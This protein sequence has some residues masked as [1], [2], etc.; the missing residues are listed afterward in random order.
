MQAKK[1]LSCGFAFLLVLAFSGVS[2]ALD[3]SDVRGTWIRIEKTIAKGKFGAV[4]SGDWFAIGDTLVVAVHTVT[5]ATGISVQLV[6]P[7]GDDA[8]EAHDV[9]GGSEHTKAATG[10][11]AATASTTDRSTGFTITLPEED[12]DTGAR[13]VRFFFGVVPGNTILEKNGLFAQV[14]VTGGGSRAGGTIDNLMD[15]KQILVGATGFATTPVGDGKTFGIDNR[16]PAHTADLFERFELMKVDPENKNKKVKIEGSVATPVADPIVYSDLNESIK[17]GQDVTVYLKLDRGVLVAGDADEASVIFVKETFLI[18]ADATPTLVTG[19]TAGLR[20]SAI[21]TV[22][23][24]NLYATGTLEETLDTS[25]GKFGDGQRVRV[26][27]YLKDEAGNLGGDAVTDANPS[28]YDGQYTFTT[29]DGGT[30]EDR[31]NLFLIDTTTPR[32]TVAYPKEGAPDST[33]L[34]AKTSQNI[35]YYHEGDGLL[36]DRGHS[37]LLKHLRLTVSEDIDSIKVSH[38]AK[39]FGKGNNDT[40][41]TID[42]SEGKDTDAFDVDL[43]GIAEYSK[44]T[45]QKRVGHATT[46]GDSLTGGI[47]GTLEIIAY[48]RAGN[49]PDSARTLANI[50]F[51]GIEPKIYNQFPTADNAPVDSKGRRTISPETVSPLFSVGE[52]LDSLSVRYVQKGTTGGADNA[53]SNVWEGNKLLY[54]SEGGKPSQLREV[55]VVPDSL[56]D[57]ED[58]YLQIV[59]VDLAGNAYV[60]PP[61]ELRFNDEFANPTADSFVVATAVKDEKA[62]VVGKAL[63]LNLTAL[64]SKMTRVEGEDVRAVVYKGQSRLRLEAEGQSDRFDGVTFEGDNVSI[65]PADTGMGIA[66][67]DGQGWKAGKRNVIVKS[68]KTLTG[69]M[70]VV[71]NID[72][73]GAPTFSSSLGPFSFDKGVFAAFTVQGLEDGEATDNVIGDFQV[74]V[75]PTDKFGNPSMKRGDFI[76]SKLDDDDFTNA[77]DGRYKTVAI[78]LSSSN[79]KVFVPGGRQEIVEEGNVFDANASETSSGTVVIT[80]FSSSPE[81]TGNDTLSFGPPAP[82]P[83][84]GAPAAPDT[85]FVEDYMGPNG[86]GDQGGMVLVSFPNSAD[87]ATVDKYQIYREL[88]VST[89]RDSIG[90]L[91]VSDDSTT[92]AWVPWAVLESEDPNA[93]E[94]RGVI[95]ALDNIATKWAVAAIGVGGSSDKTTSVNKRVFTKESVQQTLELLG[96]PE[97]D[98][99]TADELVNQFNA[100]E[101]YVKSILGDQKNL[102]FAP[103]N[104]DVSVLLGNGSVPSNIRTSG[105]PKL[106]SPKTETEEAVGAVDNIAP[107]AATDAAGALGSDG[108][109]ALS[110]TTSADDGRI[111]GIIQYRGYNLPIYG[112]KGY[113]VLRGTSADALESIGKV[114][115]GSTEFVDS[116]LPEGARVIM[117]RIDAFDDNNHEPGQLITV[118][119]VAVRAKFADADGPVYIIALDGATPLTVDFEDFIAFAAAYDSKKGDDN[120]N[121]QADVNDDG[122]VD[123]ADF[124]IASGSYLRTAVGPASK[125]AVVPQRPGVNADT[126]MRLELASEKVLVGETISVTV[127]MANARA[128]NGYGLELM[129]DADKFEFVSAVA[130][131]KDLLKSEGGETPL[132]KNWAEEGRVTVVNAIVGSGSVGGEGALVTFTFKVLREFEDSARFEIAQGVVFD[133]ERLANPVVMLG[134]LDVQS[135]P[136]EFA[137]HQNYPNPFNPQTNIPYDLAEGGDVVL[138]IYNLLGQEVRTLVRER[139]APGRYT[140]QW[141]GMDDRGVSVSSGIYFYQVSV[142]GKFQDAKRLMLLK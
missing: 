34:S 17:E 30:T 138:R 57:G 132:F 126:E 70:V 18:G 79:S 31:V 24:T 60:T 21:A 102:V 120:Y 76:D 66:T 142:A 38:G 51:D 5:N 33:H 9:V 72:D 92:N 29:D 94:Q 22:S 69:V 61:S 39:P 123:F 130:A 106:A 16:R 122:M 13:I 111:V 82:P 55:S 68:K 8:D 81:A 7:D 2:S 136:T 100:P 46:P 14:T 85:L 19:K 49:G 62:V 40:T 78:E 108:E 105:H 93:D 15:D 32:V 10:V 119:N 131:E 135:T 101:D 27:A 109:V 86:E 65:A 41:V 103:V 117:Y 129:Y 113:N 56:K 74:S 36:R 134:A 116:N 47:K 121:V 139:Q 25:E 118:Q 133:P 35:R 99:L 125:L 80:A 45:Y 84:P 104:P 28:G 107:A 96:M 71:E 97:A 1:L 64:D 53:F 87:H 140:V 11:A 44:S 128:L 112:V 4:K 42:R 110:W 88:T 127:S 90:N 58:Y 6:E 124:V 59:A 89:M 83:A 23:F 3:V 141:S 20:D 77:N 26:F 95:P 12:D 75:M 63:S 98:L 73:Q 91:I 52:D 115:V 137:L 37:K 43:S 67:L 114:D 48:D 54:N 50:T